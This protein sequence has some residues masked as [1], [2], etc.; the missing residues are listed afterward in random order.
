MCVLMRCLYS[1]YLIIYTKKWL[2]RYNKV[3]ILSCWLIS[4]STNTYKEPA[5]QLCLR[6][7][8]GSRMWK[9]V[10]LLDLMLKGRYLALS[11]GQKRNVSFEKLKFRCLQYEDSTCSKQYNFSSGDHY[12]TREMC[13]KAAE[14]LLDC[15]SS[16]I[17]L[18]QVM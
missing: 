6:R 5:L 9:K 12:K 15:T 3:L 8:A 14:N 7:Q 10:R 18:F 16:S 13:G 1:L 2:T 17:V 4:P 11:L